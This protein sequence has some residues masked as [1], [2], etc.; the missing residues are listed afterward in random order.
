MLASKSHLQ[1]YI[2][3]NKPSKPNC[4]LDFWNADHQTVIAGLLSG[5]QTSKSELM[6]N[7]PEC[8]STKVNC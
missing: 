5:M 7:F 3:K 8:R 1:I 2:L 4:R 6:V